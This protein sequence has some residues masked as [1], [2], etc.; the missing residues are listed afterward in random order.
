MTIDYWQRFLE[1]GSV[2][3]YLSYRSALKMAA[4]EEEN[5]QRNT[6]NIRN[7]DKGSENP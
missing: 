7:C 4:Q 1:S 6:E 5:E 2:R 3:D